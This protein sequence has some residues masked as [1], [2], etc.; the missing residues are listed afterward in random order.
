MNGNQPP[1]S[2]SKW[3]SVVQFFR[4][5]LD[6]LSELSVCGFGLCMAVLGAIVFLYVEQGKEVLRA[7]A[8]WS[9]PTGATN[10]R[11]ILLFGFGLF[12]WSLASWYTAR[13]LL[14]RDFFKGRERR[15]PKNEC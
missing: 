6:L 1:Q 2:D 7:L 10:V 4:R 8:E 14:D 11:R 3:Q 9:G 12:L 5:L 15:V 13:V